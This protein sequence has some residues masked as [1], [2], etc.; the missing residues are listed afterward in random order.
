MTNTQSKQ[1]KRENMKR[2][3]P[4]YTAGK[5]SRSTA[6]KYT[7]SY[8]APQQA[9]PEKKGVDFDISN[10]A[11][12]DTTNTNDDIAVMNLIQSGNG[13][14]NRIGRKV[15]LD[16]IRLKGVAECIIGLD[17]SNHLYGS[18]LR[19]LLVWDKQPS[20]GTIPT[21]DDI[22]GITEQDGTESSTVMAPPRYDNMDRFRVLM[23][24]TLHANP[25]VYNA[26]AGGDNYFVT[27][28][29]YYVKLRGCESNYSGQSQPMTIADISSGALYLV[30]R[31]TE[32]TAGSKAWQV[33]SSSVARLRY[34]D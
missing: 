19:M 11:I 30:Y 25:D 15:K 1:N 31:A 29:D 2:S 7:K 4:T 14:W 8:P 26:G 13:S 6:P 9:K 21:F 10:A 33:Q 18:A 3:A 17:G 23:D 20:S 22:F 12:V 34:T 28:F 24:K 5:K 27:P 32:N 16:S